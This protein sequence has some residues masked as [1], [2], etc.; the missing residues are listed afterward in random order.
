MKKILIGALVAAGLLSTGCQREDG[1]VVPEHNKPFRLQLSVDPIGTGVNGAPITTRAT[2]PAVEGEENIDELTLLFFEYSTS[3]TG[4]FVAEYTI[5]A[6]DTSAPIDLEIG[7]GLGEALSHTANYAILACANFTTPINPSLPSLAGKTEAQVVDEI[8]LDYK[9][10][11]GSK[12]RLPMSG[13]TTKMANQETIDLHLIRSVARLDVINEVDEYYELMDVHIS[14]SVYY[15]RLWSTDPIDEEDQT[16]EESMPIGGVVVNG[17]VTGGLY[18]FE[19]FVGDPVTDLDKTTALIVR[20]LVKDGAPVGTPGES[21]FY[22]IDLRPQESAQNIMRNN[23]Y[24]ASIERVLEKGYNSEPLACTNPPRGLDYTINNWS[25]DDEGMVVTDGQSTMAI[26]SKFVRFGAAG[27]SREYTLFTVGPGTLSIVRNNLPSGLSAVI[28]GNKLTVSATAYDGYEDRSGTIEL[29]YGG[30]R[31]TVTVIQ[32]INETQYLELDKSELEPWNSDGTDAVTP[33]NRITVSASGLWTARIYNTSADENNPG[34]SFADGSVDVEM[35]GEPGGTLDIYATGANPLN[36]FRQGFMIVTLDDDEEYSRVVVLT[37]NAKGAIRITPDYS[38]L[39]FDAVGNASGVIGMDP[40]QPQY[41]I[42][43]APG[44]DNPGD[45]LREWDYL[46]TGPD[47]AMFAVTRVDDPYA[48]YLIVSAIGEDPAYPGL[49][50]GAAKNAT[51]KIGLSIGGTLD[52][53]AIELPITQEPLAAFAVEN[54]GRLETVPTAGSERVTKVWPVGDLKHD[55]YSHM[56]TAGHVD[57]VEY[58]VE[59]HPALNYKVTMTLLN[60]TDDETLAYREH[61]GY[62]VDENGRKMTET[63]LNLGGDETVRVGFDKIYYPMVHW[64]ET[65]GSDDNNRPTVKLTFTVPAIPTLTPIEVTVEQD[66]LVAEPLDFIMGTY[67][68]NAAAGY[69]S[70][71]TVPSGI[72]LD[73]AQSMY[74]QN[75]FGPNGTVKMPNT[76]TSALTWAVVHLWPESYPVNPAR[77]YVHAA[78]FDNEGARWTDEAFKAVEAWRT[79]DD[80]HGI[81]LFTGL[82]EAQPG[83][84]PGPVAGQMYPFTNPY[85]TL[86]ILEY[87]GN[88]NHGSSVPEYSQANVTQFDSV[89]QNKR[90][91]K[92]LLGGPFGAASLTGGIDLYVDGWHATIK[93]NS[94]GSNAVVLYTEMTA[95]KNNVMAMIDPVARTA[96]LGEVQNFENHFDSNSVEINFLN[97]MMSIFMNAAMYGDHFLELLY[98]QPIEIRNTR[99]QVVG[100]W[101]APTVYLPNEGDPIIP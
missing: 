29:G 7:Y 34:F 6:P 23:I 33:A 73:F 90:L 38:A 45:P 57:V 78:A 93:R 2:V 8:I 55:R 48:P 72:M 51:L 12:D 30:L 80:T 60:N 32:S 81:V 5:D 87:D 17:G 100:T 70:F 85:S 97:N 39:P 4:R 47:A 20:L 58:G 36:D 10:G 49:N 101:T 69:G 40:V 71:G 24:V 98:E 63:T 46:L 9:Q 19:N 65:A 14:N 56:V 35:S 18:V 91:M 21:Y 22:R 31:A 44:R 61:P 52:P 68:A 99:G 54:V 15:T 25:V 95:P 11:Y 41:R 75:L 83:P 92:Y 37:Q 88:N 1:T 79:S 84:D 74:N 86:N 64:S 76:P 59:L 82:D 42:D 94:L 62:F 16:Y 26:P 27:G 66:P 3:Q 53:D 43:I 89:D 13:R 67:V 50:L 28:T 77:N 96:F